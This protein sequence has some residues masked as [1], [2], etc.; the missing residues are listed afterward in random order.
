MKNKLDDLM[1]RPKF[2]WQQHE[3][4]F[5]EFATSKEMQKIMKGT[6]EDD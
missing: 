1:R 2:K 6:Q 5:Y 4:E 3:W